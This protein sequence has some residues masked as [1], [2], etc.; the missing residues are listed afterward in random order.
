MS[1]HIRPGRD[2]CTAPKRSLGFKEVDI[3][4][5]A[6]FLRRITAPELHH[7]GRPTHTGETRALCARASECSVCTAILSIGLRMAIRLSKHTV[8]RYTAPS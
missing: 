3:P 8:V 1:A 7:I 4:Q 5:C 2:S 6:L